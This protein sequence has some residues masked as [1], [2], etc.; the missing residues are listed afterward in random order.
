[1]YKKSSPGQPVPPSNAA[2]LHALLEAGALS[3]E[4]ADASSALRHTTL[5]TY[6]HALMPDEDLQRLMKLHVKFS[7]QGVGAHGTVLLNLTAMRLVDAAD[8]PQS[9]LPPSV[10]V[11]GLS[12]FFDVTYVAKVFHVA[13]GDA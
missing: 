7:E 3:E 8:L 5:K 13:F 9:H 6:A 1:M 12:A 4:E 11:A 10:P 2:L